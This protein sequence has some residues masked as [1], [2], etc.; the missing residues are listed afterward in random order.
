[1]PPGN[2]SFPSYRYILQVSWP[3]IL[4]NMAV[5][6]LGLV[7]TAV[8]GRGG[9][10]V[11]LGAIALGALIFNFVYWTF[12]FLRMSTTG[13][14]A[15][16]VGAELELE[17]RLATARAAL[18]AATAGCGLI[19][20]CPFWSR[21]SMALLDASPA[22]EALT[23]EYVR[24]RVWGAP[25]ALVNFAVMGALIGLGRTRQLL[26]LQLFMNGLNIALDLLFAVVFG[27]G[28]AGI[29]IGTALADWSA[30]FLGAA[31]LYRVL[32]ARHVGAEPWLPW[33]DIKQYRAL[34][35]TLRVQRDVLLRTLCLLFGFGWFAQQGARFGDTTLAA[36]HLLQLLISFSAFFLDGVAFS[37]ESLA[38][39]AAGARRLDTFRRTIR[40]TTLVAFGLAVVLSAAVATVGNDAIAALTDVAEV[41]AVASRHLAYAA[42]YVLVAVFAFQLDGVFVGT[43]RTREMR[44]ASLLSV[45]S[46]VTLER[47]LTP[48]LGNHGLWL[49]MIGFAAARG[50]S[51]A[52][53]FPRIQR[54]LGAALR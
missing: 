49:A 9:T 37:T 41:R 20:L 2:D 38:G 33:D 45:V 40:R 18:L 22:V 13:L 42:S 50:L 15:R 21:L 10:A 14:V 43:T 24:L 1:M 3:I 8:I 52:W 16:A 35:E 19:L 34:R 47:F 12:G 7:D 39:N 31:L 28:V 25:A 44:N 51:L 36:N 11:A 48:A 17:V 54:Q 5:P 29:A 27:W 53:F 46:F 23:E 26:V 6:L 32:R 30:A 4:A